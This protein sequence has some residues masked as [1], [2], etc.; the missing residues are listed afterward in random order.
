M[1]KK[2]RR[3]A[4]K[5][6]QKRLARSGVE[7]K[8]AA[9]AREE[10]ETLEKTTKRVASMINQLHQAYQLD[11]DDFPFMPT[12]KYSQEKHRMKCARV[13]I[14]SGEKVITTLVVRP[15]NRKEIRSNPKAQVRLRNLLSDVEWKLYDTVQDC[16]V[17]F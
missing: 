14:L 17:V 1:S 13:E 10:L 5:E 4:I 9:R 7:K 16:R 2:A 15:V 12:C 6:E 11:E 3:E 8:R